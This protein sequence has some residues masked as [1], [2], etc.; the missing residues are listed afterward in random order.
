MSIKTDK[1]DERLEAL[2]ASLA[3]GVMDL[4]SSAKW[5]AWLD[6]SAGFWNYSFNNQMLILIQRPDA[7]LVTGYR[8]WE[9]K[10]RQ[11]RKGEKSIGIYAPMIRK[12]TDEVTGKERSYVAGFRI[13]SVFDIGQTEGDP[14]PEDVT[15]TSLLEGDAPE[16]LYDAMVGVATANKYRVER[17]DCHGA[18]GFTRPSDRLIMVR[19]DVSDL[20]AFK[21][22][23]HELAHMLL[24]CEDADLTRD[25]Q[26]HRDVAEVEAESVAYIVSKALGLETS[27]YS[28]PY[29]AAWGGKDAQ[30]KITST[31]QRVVKTA[32]VI[33]DAATAAFEAEVAVA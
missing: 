32:R 13:A 23:V 24:H 16:M 27:P 30:E 4:T 11:V 9:S 20:Q 21:T 22:L 17:G 28:L 19:E 14:I 3:A 6:F 15:R 26:A 1:R 8:K 2:H 12:K 5:Q 31:G 29:V 7:T 18:N 10:G 33:I 25:A